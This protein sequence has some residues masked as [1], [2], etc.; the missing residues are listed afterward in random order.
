MAFQV[1]AAD[2]VT[3]EDGT[4]THTAVMYAKRMELNKAGLPRCIS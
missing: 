3:T 4:G 1:Y 2:F